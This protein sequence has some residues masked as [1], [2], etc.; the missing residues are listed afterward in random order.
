M[1]LPSS[2]RQVGERIRQ[3]RTGRG[4][5]VRTLAAT[6][7][8]SPSFISQ[9]EHGQVSPS[10][11]SL[12][13]I[14]AAL[15]MTLGGFF[16]PSAPSPVAVVRATERQEITSSWSRGTIEALGSVGGQRM[17]EPLLITL[18][19][20]GRSGNRLHAALGEQFAFV[21]D[22]EV[23]L[24][25]SENTYVLRSGDAVSIAAATPHQWE[26]PAASPARV[27]IISVH[28]NAQSDGTPS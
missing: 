18:L 2:Q 6:T 17:L 28:A 11:A 15:G 1:T 27:L 8:F 10:I 22:G 12:E 20:A 23:T 26:N 13:R 19:P 25:L 16:T 21:C 5:S 24:T 4:L 9:V 3:L 7:G 14:A